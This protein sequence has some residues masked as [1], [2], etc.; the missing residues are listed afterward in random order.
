[1]ANRRD[2]LKNLAVLQSAAL[3]GQSGAK[4]PDATITAAGAKRSKEPFGDHWVYFDGKTDQLRG[5]TGGSLRLKAGASPHP[6]HQHPEEEILLVTE[7]AGEISIEGKAVA[8]GP[9]AMMY[10][11]ANKVHGIQNTGKTPML[12]Y[13]FKWRA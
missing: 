11:A 5:F 10:C 12:F 8:A 7:G 9:G 6:P 3:F 2:I 13:Y 4:L 1:M